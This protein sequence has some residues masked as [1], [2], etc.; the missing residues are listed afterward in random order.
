MHLFLL[1]NLVPTSKALVTSS[2]ALVP[3]SFL[4]LIDFLLNG[5]LVSLHMA[6]QAPHTPPRD[7][8][9]PGT[10]GDRGRVPQKKRGQW[11]GKRCWNTQI[12]T[13]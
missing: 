2:D 4:F 9:L 11:V 7:Q 8:S 1:A 12:Q 13:N 6:L 3:S 5:L 10:R